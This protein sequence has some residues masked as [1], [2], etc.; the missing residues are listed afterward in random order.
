MSDDVADRADVII[1][2]CSYSIFAPESLADIKCRLSFIEASECNCVEGPHE[3]ALHDLV[4]D[5]VPVLLKVVDQLAA[6]LKTTQAQR[7]EFHAQLDDA[8]KDYEAV[9]A[10]LIDMVPPE[11]IDM[12]LEDERQATHAPKLRHP[13][14]R[15]GDPSC[16]GDW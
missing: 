4:H 7:D 11:V 5:D 10:E 12:P 6:E 8:L 13:L 2:G 9:R 16:G 3:N 14:G 15:C 1:Q